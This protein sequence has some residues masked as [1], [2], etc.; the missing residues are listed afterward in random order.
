MTKCLDCGYLCPMLE[1]KDK[2]KDIELPQIERA[3]LPEAIPQIAGVQFR[4]EDVTHPC[5]L[6]CFLRVADFPG[7]PYRRDTQGWGSWWNGYPPDQESRTGRAYRGGVQALKEPEQSKKEENEKGR[8]V[9]NMLEALTQDWDCALFFQHI[10]GRKPSY[11]QDLQ[12]KRAMR[13]E[14]QRIQKER[15][16]QQEQSESR[17]RRFKWLNLVVSLV[18]EVISRLVKR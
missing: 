1:G 11:H 15:M 12:E 4:F 9:K 3:K 17:D 6:G 14:D 18:V 7:E 16:G 8:T 2:D 5:H 10:P 13:E